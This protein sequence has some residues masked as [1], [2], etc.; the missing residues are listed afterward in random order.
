MELFSTVAALAAEDVSRSTRR[1]YADENGFVG[2]PMS[3]Y[4]GH[5]LQTVACLPERNES[6]V[7][8]DSRQLNLFTDLYARFPLESV[9]YYVCYGDDM[10]SPFLGFLLQLR[11]TCHRSVLV[12]DFHEYAGRIHSSQLAE[13]YGSFRMT[14]A[15][16]HTVILCVKRVDVSRTSESLRCTLRV[17]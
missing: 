7:T 14:G 3:F 1:V 11:H 5:M 6:E 12:H 4:Q 8:V 2:L 16:Q 9:L 17:C 13:V 15:A 10:Q